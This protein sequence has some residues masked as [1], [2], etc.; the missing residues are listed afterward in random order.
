MS[1]ASARWRAGLLLY[2][3]IQFI[4]LVAIAMVV[5]PGGYDLATNFLSELGGTRTW[6]GQ[7]NTTGAVLFSIALAS[8][9]VAFV[10]FA[11]AWRAFAFAHGR[12]RPAGVAAQLFG[13]GSGAAFVA[14]AVTPVNLAVDLHNTFV[15]AAFGLL[16]GYAA[17]MTIVSWRNGI[18]RGQ[19]VASAAYLAVVAAYFAVVAYG[20]SAD[21]ATAHGRMILV[22]SQKVIV[23]TSMLFVA[24]LTTATRR[25]LSLRST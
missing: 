7:A 21:V 15:V 16:L 1:P 6:T 4:V 9:G 19:L 2:A 20:A 22:V 11:G 13:T 18:P 10:A 17:A 12:A 14:V 3:A 5:F 24:Y 8:L 23:G 25:Q